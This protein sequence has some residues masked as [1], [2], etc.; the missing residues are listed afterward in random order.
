MMKKIKNMRKKPQKT[1]KS[2]AFRLILPTVLAVLI[3][4]S[5]MGGL[6]YKISEQIYNYQTNQT[7]E[8][9]L[10]LSQRA[11]EESWRN[12][13][14]AALRTK[15]L[16]TQY[17]GEALG[18][19]LDLLV[20]PPNSGV[21]V[22]DSYTGDLL[23]IYPRAEQPLSED[24]IKTALNHPET[25]LQTM[26]LTG[27]GFVSSVSFSPLGLHIIS[28]NR[29][30]FNETQIAPLMQMTIISTLA[31][32]AI[33]LI[34]MMLSLLTYSVIR[35]LKNISKNISDIIHDDN[36][37]HQ[38]E[39]NTGA[40]E[41]QNLTSQF[42]TLLSYIEERDSTLKIHNEKLEDLVSARTKELKNA[43]NR[44][45]LGE[46]LAAIGEFASSVAHELRNPLSS[47][48][49][50]VDKLAELKNIEGNDRRRLE[51]IQK[52]VDRLSSML[53]GIL[54]FAAPTPVNLSTFSIGT[55]MADIEP[56]F[57]AFAKEQKV[58]LNLPK[59]P[60]NIGVLGDVDKL[61]QA[62]INCVKNAC[63]AAPT[64]SPVT[65]TFHTDETLF[66]VSIHNGGDVIKADV[67]NRLFEPF[68]TTK[69]EGTGL[70]LPTTK[71]LM[72]EMGGDI[73]VK[74]SAKSGTVCHI[75]LPIKK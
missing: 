36:F 30:G 48:K 45:V 51:L 62:L 1:T 67:L 46:R 75:T 24:I 5:L 60:D 18:N 23:Q 22:V 25:T 59:W 37:H 26:P 55:V 49:M 29:Q 7:L 53:K 61:K 66:T 2:L 52:E 40:Q 73:S 72:G 39:S 47:I 27:G 21:M 3:T 74:S 57:H 70:G 10:Q 69:A 68:F 31:I 38:M 4:L 33:I 64:K 11:L 35:P 17:T 58:V 6:S 54:S 56:I 13:S 63:E 19:T 9:N 8:N 44:L 32:T 71:R 42:N 15:E 16:L 20:F 34:L 43:Q 12:T 28:F 50:G 65:L 41:L 14:G